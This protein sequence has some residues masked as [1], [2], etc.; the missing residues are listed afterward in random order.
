MR[1]LQTAEDNS[2]HTANVSELAKECEKEWNKLKSI[3]DSIKSNV[4]TS[5]TF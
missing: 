3:L 2:G 5:D 1:L 4:K